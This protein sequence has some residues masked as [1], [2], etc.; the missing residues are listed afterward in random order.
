MF[1]STVGH[2][3]LCLHLIVEKDALASPVTEQT[4]QATACDQKIV[5]D[6]LMTHLSNEIEEK[7]SRFD[8][9]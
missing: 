2:V 1:S 9:E 7:F 5:L 8:I 6:H 3:I 4:A